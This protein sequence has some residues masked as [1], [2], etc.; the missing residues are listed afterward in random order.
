MSEGREGEVGL[1]IP[2]ELEDLLWIEIGKENGIIRTDIAM[3][4]GV[5]GMKKTGG[6]EE[7][8]QTGLKRM[9]EQKID[10]G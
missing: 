8:M 1:L 6:V 9:T 2:G 10:Q 3:M 5:G 4:S 7:E